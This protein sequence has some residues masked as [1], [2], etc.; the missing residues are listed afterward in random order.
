MICINLMSFETRKILRAENR[1]RKR[2]RARENAQALVY[3]RA[4]TPEQKL[5]RKEYMRQWQIDNI[6]RKRANERDWYSRNKKVKQRI[7]RKSKYGPTANEHIETQLRLQ[8]NRCPIC[9][10][11]LGTG[12]D[13]HLDHDHETNQ[14]RGM[15]CKQCNRALGLFYENTVTLQRAIVYLVKWRNDAIRQTAPTNVQSIQ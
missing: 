2:N 11:P 9:D 14:L 4:L 12:C 13:V 10:E 15:L 8:E 6:D 3:R 5:A 7:D 1:K